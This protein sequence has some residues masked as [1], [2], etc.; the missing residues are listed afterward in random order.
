MKKLSV[1]IPTYNRK[2]RLEKTFPEVISNKSD[3]IEFIVVDNNSKDD[4]AE[5][6]K[7]LAK[8]DD[9]IRYF[10]NYI[11]LGPNRTIYRAILEAEADW[12]IIV[13][14]DDFFPNKFF[15][16]IIEQISANIGCGLIIPARKNQG[17]LLFDKTKILSGGEALRVSY[18][19]SSTITGLVWNKHSI[20]EPAWLLDGFIY[21]QVRVSTNIALNNDL[22]YFVSNHMPEILSWDEDTLFSL[23]RPIDYGFFELIDILDEICKKIKSKETLEFY[24][25]ASASKFVWIISIFNE[26]YKE[27]KIKSLKF[28]N[29]L[30]THRSIRSSIIFWIILFRNL[31]IINP[32]LLFKTFLGFIK[33]ISISVFD[34][35]LYLSSYYLIRKINYFKRKELELKT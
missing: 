15:D 12:V 28:L 3:E 11:N 20:N 1:L 10:K 17:K 35:N 27:D 7:E 32:N 29:N 5:Y 18:L 19:H 21:P 4:T 30:F 13:P 26:M 2:N 31:K 33:G 24:Y 23:P 16:D 9:R 22:M 14:D 25:E 34:K 6:I 8:Y